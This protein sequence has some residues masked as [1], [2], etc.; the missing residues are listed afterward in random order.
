[1]G[2]HEKFLN[3]NSQKEKILQKVETKFNDTVVMVYFDDIDKTWL[4]PDIKAYRTH[5]VAKQKP[6]PVVIYDYYDNCEYIFNLK[7][8]FC[9]L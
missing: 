4:S 2:H 7:L 8:V 5:K 9:I 6:A 3:M 1:M